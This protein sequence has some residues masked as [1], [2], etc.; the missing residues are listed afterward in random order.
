[1]PL[2]R[3]KGQRPLWGLGQRPNCP[4]VRPIPKVANKGAGSA[5]SPASNF[6]RP[7]TRPQAA[8]PPSFREELFCVRI[9]CM[10][11][12][13]PGYDRNTH[14]ERMQERE[15]RRMEERKCVGWQEQETSRLFSAVQEARAAAHRFGKCSRTYPWTWDANPTAFATT[16]TPAC[17][18]RSRIHRVYRRSFP[19]RRRRRMT[20]CVRC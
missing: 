5:A 12:Y 13:A 4:L 15:E 7:Q 11:A 8:F 9:L 18:I 6:A 17:G 14:P 2:C 16:I 19:S 10:N 20:S 3:V 1:M